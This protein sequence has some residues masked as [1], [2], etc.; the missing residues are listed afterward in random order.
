MSHGG[1]NIK[2]PISGSPAKKLSPS[3]SKSPGTGAAAPKAFTNITEV[4]QNRDGKPQVV[5]SMGNRDEKLLIQLAQKAFNTEFSTYYFDRDGNPVTV[6]VGQDDEQ[7]TVKVA[8]VTAIYKPAHTG[9][10]RELTSG[11][12]RFK[13][14]NIPKYLACTVATKKQLEQ[15]DER[16]SSFQH[17]LTGLE[18]FKEDLISPDDWEVS[19]VEKTINVTICSQAAFINGNG[20]DL[21]K[22][23]ILE[24]VDEV[25]GEEVKG[26]DSPG[27]TYYWGCNSEYAAWVIQPDKVDDFIELCKV[28]NI[29]GEVTNP[30]ALEGA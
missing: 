25:I 22:D 26:I 10:R 19:G 23:Y 20:V 6:K 13:N 11:G 12:L 24:S 2:K 4:V 29:L 15:L 16:M 18:S 21:V 7:I 9:T 28:N 5:Y 27:V 14:K 8:N 30:P 17:D 3:K 1:F